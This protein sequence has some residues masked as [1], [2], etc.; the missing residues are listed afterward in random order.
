MQ[1]RNWTRRRG[2]G[3][4]QRRRLEAQVEKLQQRLSDAGRQRQQE[5][6]DV[7]P[8]RALLDTDRPTE[9]E[10]LLQRELS[11]SQQMV[12]R[13]H[14][15]TAEMKRR[16]DREPTT[17]PMQPPAQPV[18]QP[19]QQQQLIRAM[20]CNTLHSALSQCVTTP[21]YHRN[22]TLEFERQACTLFGDEVR[23]IQKYLN[24]SVLSHNE[25]SQTDDITSRSEGSQTDECN[26]MTDAIDHQREEQHPG[27][28]T[29]CSEGSQ[30]VV[31]H[32]SGCSLL[33]PPADVK[34]QGVRYPLFAG[35]GTI[36]ALKD[37]PFDSQVTH[38]RQQHIR[39]SFYTKQIDDGIYL[40]NYRDSNARN[41][42]HGKT[43]PGWEQLDEDLCARA[44]LRRECRGL[45]LRAN[46]TVLARP[47][48]KFF[49]VD[50]LP[51]VKLDPDPM[52]YGMHCFSIESVTKKLDGQ[53]LMGLVI[54]GH[55][56]LWTRAGPT[57]VGMR[58]WAAAEALS[59]DYAGFIGHVASVYSTPVFEYIGHQSHIKAFEQNETRIV[60]VAI[61][62]NQ[63]GEYWPD[64]AAEQWA[65][66]YGIPIVQRMAYMEGW[67]INKQN[68]WSLEAIKNHV[69]GWRNMEGVVVRFKCG[70][71]L[72]IKS[73]W[74]C[75]TGYTKRFTNKIKDRLDAS[76]QK[77]HDKKRRHQ[78]HSLRLAVTKL[79][80]STSVANIASWFPTARKVE[81]V[82]NPIG[83]L[84][85]AMLAFD[86]MVERDRVLVNPFSS[87]FILEKAYSARTRTNSK[88]V[89][90]NHT[91]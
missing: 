46:G 85:L 54:A 50:Q 65:Q 23:L 6:R 7:A 14:R 16:L 30:A 48:H 57:D 4:A 24:T 58:A 61:R 41:F 44:N 1:D 3:H 22:G 20:I 43:S 18:Q 66:R 91:F 83:R 35:E 39:E 42:V 78:H 75:D 81:M 37:A 33:H 72:K 26:R 69:Y 87:D 52:R 49:T 32:P 86:S 36:Q 80:Y 15:V 67:R 47:L 68:G 25:G 10:V 63:S 70:L 88:V 13:L 38:K 76:K 60:L 11:E 84:R 45:V 62:F 74:W 19:M 90:T 53:M 59:G 56:Q 2:K 28:I 31:P 55:P 5:Q 89:V 9:R 8:P 17:R 64:S 73:K 12:E 29:N 71:W 34:S 40:Y 77:V 27:D 79:H 51:E 21:V 82:Y